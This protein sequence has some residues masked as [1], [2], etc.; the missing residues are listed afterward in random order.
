MSPRHDGLRRDRDGSLIP[1]PPTD[2]P[3]HPVGCSDG[4]W[5]PVSDRALAPCPVC[6]PHTIERLRRNQALLDRQLNPER[7]EPS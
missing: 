5:I 1:T 6:R 2:P 4:G 7:K 3:P